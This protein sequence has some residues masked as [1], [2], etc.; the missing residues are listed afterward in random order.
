MKQILVTGGSGF[1]GSHLCKLLLDK[2]EEVI[3]MDN[4]FTGSKKNIL[5]LMKNPN[6][7]ILRHDIIQ[8]IYLEVDQIYNLACP[9]S[10]VHYQFDPI[11]TTLTSTVGIYNML[12][13]AKRC[14][15]RILQASTS[16][17]YGDPEEHPQ[18]ETYRGNVSTLG[19]RACFSEDTEVL[20]KNGWKLFKNITYDDEILTLGKNDFVEYH[21]PSEII[22]ERYIGE[23]IAFKN[24]KLDLLVTPNH[25]MYAK[26]RH[27]NKFELLPALENIRWERAE[28]KK[29][30]KWNGVE[31]KYFY[32]PFVKN[33][34]FGHVKKIDMDVWNEFFGYYITEG[35]VHLRKRK[36]TVKRKKYENIEYNILI[37]QSKKNQFERKKIIECLKKMPFTFFSSDDHQFRICNKQLAMYLV[38]F[39][40]AKEKYIPKE[41]KNLSRRQLRILFDALMLGDGSK[42]KRAFY[43]SSITLAGDFQEILLK[44]G[45]AASINVKDKRKKNP[46][47]HVHILTDNRKDFLTPKYPKREI[48]N[49]DGYVY[50]VNVP[51]H[52]IYIRRN[53]KVLFCGNCYDEGK[54]CAETFMMDYHRENN[55]DI[56][57][58]RIFN[59]YGPNMA[60]NDG[61]VIS[62]FI[63][64]ALKNKPITVYGDGKQTRSFCYVSDLIKGMYKMMNN[65]NF[66]GPFN[67]GNPEEYT[68]LQ[69][70]RKIIELT[71][72]KSKIVFKELPKDDPTRRKPDISLAKE[73]LDWEPS[74]KLEEGLKKTIEY[75]KDVI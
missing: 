10:P 8:P 74:V 61:R 59:T 26:K 34:K 71:D 9:A 67:L 12:G 68:I 38:Q 48:T 15:A 66:I 1:I 44:L 46:V 29:S 39:G 13:I 51:N 3:C 18:K 17:I 6:F 73:K 35:C 56:R 53:G 41:L 72:S 25:K 20:T 7:E 54:R 19:P 69:L 5:P 24:S 58:I 63:V 49:Y 64:Q 57:I 75:F 62:N 22:K 47:Y 21:K 23:L 70:A 60:M 45:M 52:V 2:G 33:N 27:K 50:C 16:E 55:V 40:K 11:K 65:K 14:K 32:L 4:F 30:A 37:A 36:R 31:K 42:D 43:S 28:M